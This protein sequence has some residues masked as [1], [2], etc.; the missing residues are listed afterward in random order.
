[1]LTD[2]LQQGL[3]DRFEHMKHLRDYPPG[4]VAR[5]RQYVEAML[6]LEVYSHQLY[7]VMHG[8]FSPS[9]SR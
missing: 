5:A 6:G 9:L 4:D 7:L 1:M 2:T 8:V 3:H